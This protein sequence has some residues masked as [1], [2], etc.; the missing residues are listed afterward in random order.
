[1]DAFPWGIPTTHAHALKEPPSL[2]RGPFHHQQHSCQGGPLPQLCCVQLQSM[3]AVL[4]LLEG[5]VVSLSADFADFIVGSRLQMLKMTASVFGIPCV[6]QPTH[7]LSTVESNDAS[8][9][10]QKTKVLFR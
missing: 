3:S 4:G 6:H 7:L 8:K 9:C 5:T 10:A 1:M 2:T